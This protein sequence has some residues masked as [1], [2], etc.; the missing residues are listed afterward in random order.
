[1]KYPPLKFIRASSLQNLQ[2]HAR[3]GRGGRCRMVHHCPKEGRLAIANVNSFSKR[4]RSSFLA[5]WDL[6]IAQKKNRFPI[7]EQIVLQFANSICSPT[8]AAWIS[9]GK[10]NKV[11]ELRQRIILVSHPKNKLELTKRW[12]LRERTTWP[13]DEFA[14][15]SRGGRLDSPPR[16]TVIL[17]TLQSGSREP[18]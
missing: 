3:L 18:R 15:W 14:E 4:Q 16:M 17:A 11:P 8:R 1:M 7:L 13:V 6:M 2:F 10:S 9:S 12:A 5:E